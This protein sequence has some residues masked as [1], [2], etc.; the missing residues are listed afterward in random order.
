MCIGAVAA[1]LEYQLIGLTVSG[2]VAEIF[3]ALD[4]KQGRVRLQAL[5]AEWLR[6]DDL[7]VLTWSGKSVSSGGKTLQSGKLQSLRRS[8]RFP[9]P[10]R[11]REV[12]HIDCGR[13]AGGALANLRAPAVQHALRNH[14]FDA[15]SLSR[16]VVSGLA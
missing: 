4:Q 12:R 6:M 1:P 8:K 2:D 14:F 7:V 13:F 16:I 9:S 5:I 10:S 11:R 15:R 3:S